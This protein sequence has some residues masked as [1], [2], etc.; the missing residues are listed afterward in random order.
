MGG[1]LKVAGRARE[2]E[3]ANGALKTGPGLY[4]AGPAGVGKSHFA[5][6]VARWAESQGTTVIRVRAT[7]GSSEL[8]L[9]AFLAQLAGTERL[10]TPMFAEIRD[11]I[12]ERA[13]G[14]PI[15]LS[16]DDVHLLDDTSAVLIHQMVTAGEAQLLAT[17][18]TGQLAPREVLDLWQRGELRRLDIGPFDRANAEAMADGVLDLALDAGTHERLWNLA[19]GN[20]LYIRELL[21]AADQ[22]GHVEATGQRASV[23]H[24]PLTAP[25]LADTVRAR[26][27]HLDAAAHT[28]LVHLAF[29]EPCGPAELAS[30]ADAAM[31]AALEQSELISVTNDERRLS[32]RLAHPLYAEVLR[33]GTPLLQRRAILGVLAGDLLATGARRRADMVKLAR[34][35]VD[36]GVYVEP[37]VLI[38]AAKI[39]YHAGD[40]V[41]CERIAR[42]AFETAN[43]FAAGWELANCLYGE[44]DLAGAAEH[45]PKW[46]LLAAN[47]GQ[48]L[49]V[50]LVESQIVYWAGEDET[51]ALRIV[52]AALDAFADDDDYEGGISHDE[53][54]ANR[55]MLDAC[56]GR[57]LRSWATAER[58]LEH[59]PDQTLVR[60]AVAASHALRTLGRPIDAIAALTRADD[61]FA[62]MGQEAVSLSARVVL[63]ARALAY[64]QIGD[65]A[66][67][68]ADVERARLDAISEGQIGLAYLVMSYLEVLRGRPVQARP[69]V[70]H[71]SSW[72]SRLI[73]GVSRRW[74]LAMQAYVYASCG[75]VENT[76]RVLDQYDVDRHPS[77]LFDFLVAIARSRSAFATGQPEA[78]RAIVRDEAEK[79]RV[80]CDLVGEANCLYELVRLDRA[81]EVSKR[82]AEVGAESQG[83]LIAAFAAHAHA[84]ATD[85]AVALADAGERLAGMGLNLYAS[86][87]FAQASDAHRRTGDQR[88]AA[89]LLVRAS[90]L[91]AMCDDQVSAS[92]VM[93]AGPVALTRR[94]RE[95]AVLAAQGLASKEIGD[96]L[97]I[98]RRTA[99]NHLAKVYDKLGVRTR[100]ELA[101]LLDGGVHALAS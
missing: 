57:G 23:S 48:H 73:G 90:E 81:E 79:M 65:L 93:D 34:L 6:E 62:V 19:R 80:Y 43:S 69:L 63:A 100:I 14:A 61:A 101:R 8:P 67:A 99:E 10:L 26:L 32:I 82:F 53:L 91:R 29:A 72:T 40:R 78:A 77:H 98:S 88:T 13:N 30:V 28:A 35:G 3:Q 52:Y 46:R 31:L 36:G 9:G 60:A 12:K 25:R 85:D 75:D 44:G 21:L 20:A 87:A 17:L 50:A 55:A 84:A 97:Y 39:T 64:I 22:E 16:V 86:E 24:L 2:S 4:L 83:D 38:A 51:E 33:V 7:A 1:T 41:L 68:R 94:E 89:R 45:F 92:P 96:R 15:L 70:E 49:A 47:A 27:G 42:R 58:L 5:E 54:L 71:A 37:G 18:R 11:R 59:G 95:I 66:A 56:S 74:I 76:S